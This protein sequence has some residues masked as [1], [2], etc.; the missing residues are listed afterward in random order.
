[1]V[2]AKQP[3]DSS[4][5]EGLLL[6]ISKNAPE[7]DKEIKRMRGIRD[8][9]VAAQQKIRSLEMNA[10]KNPNNMQMAMELGATQI[11]LGDHDG[12]FLTFKRLFARNPDYLPAHEFLL[13]YQQDRGNAEMVRFHQ[14]TIEQ[15]MGKDKK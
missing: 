7:N 13:Q 9:V 11:E 2:L 5:L 12:A 6:C 14:K 1:M 3:K 8:S 10:L 15:I 4:A